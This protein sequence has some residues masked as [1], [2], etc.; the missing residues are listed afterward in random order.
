[1]VRRAL[2]AVYL[3]YSIIVLNYHVLVLQPAGN[4]DRVQR[5]ALRV[6][7]RTSQGKKYQKHACKHLFS[8]IAALAAWGCGLFQSYP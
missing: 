7:F 3:V 4:P 8:S 6:A 2:G 1:M 5:D